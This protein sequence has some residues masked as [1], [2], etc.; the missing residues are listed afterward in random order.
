VLSPT[1]AGTVGHYEGEYFAGKPAVTLNPFGDGR[2]LYVGA[3]G[4]SALHDLL[5]GWLVEAAALGSSARTPS[6]VEAVERSGDGRRLLFLMNHSDQSQVVGLDQTL[7]DLLTGKPVECALT[8]K[9]YGVAV[10]RE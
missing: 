6:G 8:L 1:T 5:V 7:T 4:D 9:P 2:T 10:L 3:I